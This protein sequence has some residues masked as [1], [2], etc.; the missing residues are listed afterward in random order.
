MYA[1]L[2]RR[3]YELLDPRPDDYGLDR[4]VNAGI[5]ALIIL[6]VVAAILETVPELARTY[7]PIFQ[8][9]EQASMAVFVVE[10]L[11]RV[12]SAIEDPEQGA[13]PYRRLRYMLSPAALIDAVVI[14]PIVVASLFALDVGVLRVVRL[15]RVFM[16]LRLV[17]YSAAVRMLV[18]VMKR[19][20][21][22]L[23]VTLTIGLMLLVLASSLMYTVENTVQPEAFP[24]IPAAMWWGVATLTTVGYGD[25][26]PMTALG[27]LLGGTIA[28][29]GVGL[30]ALPAGILASGISEELHNQR[31]DLRELRP[32]PTTVCPHCEGE[33]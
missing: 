13:R 32:R 26:Y 23:L 24:H 16:L 15:L 33:L 10:Y 5:V 2:R 11:A 8:A 22:A 1:R 29:L 25:I 28:V 20:S 17:R 9:F 21:E 30:F 18:N 7:D 14:V 12:W 4:V 3:T 31:R 27:R 6:N 19:Q